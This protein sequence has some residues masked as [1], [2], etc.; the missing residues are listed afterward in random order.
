[1]LDIDFLWTAKDAIIATAAIVM[2]LTLI[3]T[4]L[5]G[6]LTFVVRWQIKSVNATP[7]GGTSNADISRKLDEHIST[8]SQ[9]VKELKTEVVDMRNTINNRIDHALSTIIESRPRQ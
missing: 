7:N 6:L 8:H 4:P 9:D 5:F 3:I 1:M 2:A